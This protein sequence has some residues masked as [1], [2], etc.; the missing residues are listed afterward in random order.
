MEYRS[1]I[2]HLKIKFMD[3]TV[4]TLQVRVFVF[5]F[6]FLKKYVS[7]LMLCVSNNCWWP[8]LYHTRMQTFEFCVL[9]CCRVVCFLAKKRGTC[10]TVWIHLLADSKV[11]FLNYLLEFEL[12]VFLRKKEVLVLQCGFIYSQIAK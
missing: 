11:I 7:V 3:G 12:S 4:K 10:I 5:M 9:Y 1:K 2:R 8:F 6:V